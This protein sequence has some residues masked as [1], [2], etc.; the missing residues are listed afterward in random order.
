MSSNLFTSSGETKRSALYLGDRITH[1]RLDVIIVFPCAV[2][3]LVHTPSSED[4]MN[5]CG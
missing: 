1:T 5:A 2:E 4:D 3:S